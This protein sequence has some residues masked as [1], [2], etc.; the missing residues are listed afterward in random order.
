MEQ[1]A[2]DQ[3]LVHVELKLAIHASNGA[4]NIVAHHLSADHG[5]SLTLRRVD[6][7]GHNTGAGLVL[8]QV[9]LSQTTSRTAAEVADILRNLGERRSYSVEG[10]V[11]LDDGIVGSKSLE[12]VGCRLELGSSHLRNLLS[13]ALSEAFEGVDTGTN[14]SATLGQLAQLRQA[15]LDSLDAE[16]KLSYISRE[17][18]R[19]GQGS[20]ILQMR[21]A[22]LDDLLGLELINLL[23]QRIPQALHA[24][25][26]L[27]LNFQDSGDVHD[28]REGI[29]GGGGAVDMVVGMDRLFGAHG[30]AQDLDGAVR[31]DFVG[32]HVGLG[33]RA[34]LP[35]NEGEVV[36]QL[37]V[38]DLLGGLLDGSTDLGV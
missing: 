10:A 38:S 5:Q 12:L 23:L 30:A 4:S 21:P 17:L 19:Q 37:Q 6:L 14:S 2:D 9:Q 8:R 29:I 25:Y 32:V 11:G 18:L 26:E 35:N 34:G 1:V 3:G 13:N 7:S 31:D 15:G 22:N 28:G 16:I 36:E 24:R 33:A 20:G 27:I